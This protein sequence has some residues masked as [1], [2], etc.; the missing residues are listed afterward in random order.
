MITRIRK[1]EP[2]NTESLETQLTANGIEVVQKEKRQVG[3]PKIKLEGFSQKVI[4]EMMDLARIGMPY[5]SIAGCLN[6]SYSKFLEL[7]E[8]NPGWASMM[9]GQRE[10]FVSDN[11]AKLRRHAN[12]SPQSA[13]WLLERVRPAEFSSKAELRVSGSVNNNVTLD[14]SQDLCAKL[15]EARRA[16]LD[17]VLMENQATTTQLSLPTSSSSASDLILERN[18]SAVEI[19]AEELKSSQR[20]W[21]MTL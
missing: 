12:T 5:K 4:K 15:A 2:N 8:E 20:G 17:G 19:T 9:D 11:L 3:R 16:N 21:R 1:V 6:I 7:R 18:Q 13:Q 14:V 10:A